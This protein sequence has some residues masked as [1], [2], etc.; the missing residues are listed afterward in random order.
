MSI[1][2]HVGGYPEPSLL[3]YKEGQQLETEGRFLHIGDAQRSDSGIYECV[4]WNIAGQSQAAVQLEY[5]S[6]ADHYNLHSKY[7]IFCEPLLVTICSHSK[8][9]SFIRKGLSTYVF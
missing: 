8:P 2:C 5:T 3:W 1:E 9:G 7:H 6:K 4:A